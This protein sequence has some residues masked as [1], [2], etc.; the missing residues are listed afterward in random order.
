MNNA[1]LFVTGGLTMKGL[2]KWLDHRSKLV[3][4]ILALPFLDIVWGIYRICRSASKKNLIGT[5][6]AV[7]ILIIG[8]P[9]LWLLDI[10]TIV[11]MDRVLWID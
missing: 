6:L 4:I 11:L 5:I 8:I 9:L 7:L 10:I 3:K 2:I 1:I